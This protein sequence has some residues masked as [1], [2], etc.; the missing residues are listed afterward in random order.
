MKRV[1]TAALAATALL[2]AGCAGATTTDGG[3]PP[4]PS[5][6][7]RVPGHGRD[8]TLDK[9]PER[10]VSLS[11]TGDRDA[12]R[13]RRREAGHRR[14]RPVDLPGRR[15]RRPTCPASSRTP[16]RSPRR[17][18]TSWSSP[19]T[20][21]RS[22]ISSTALKIPVLLDAG[23]Q[24]PRRHVQA[25]RRARHAHRA[26]GRGERADRADEGRDH[27][28]R[29][30]RCR[31][32]TDAAHLLLRARPDALHGHLQDVRRL[33]VRACSG[34]PTSPTRPTPTGRRAATRSCRRRR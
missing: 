7:R 22:S 32:A 26:P 19:T 12:L 14:R 27:Q 15:A 31:S 8:L 2:L 25:D 3:E 30:R 5:A 24:D 34:W 1:L 9:R 29:R 33:A 11:P 20:S 4:A 16:R 6:E 13:D 18:P 28:D 10:I 17:S 23:G 21:T